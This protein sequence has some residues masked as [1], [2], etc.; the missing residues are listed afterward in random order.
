MRSSRTRF[1]SFYAPN[2]CVPNNSQ[3]WVGP[4]GSEGALFSLKIKQMNSGLSPFI[5][6]LYNKN[7]NHKKLRFIEQLLCA[8][9]CTKTFRNSHIKS[10]DYPHQT[11]REQG[12][13]GAVVSVECVFSMREALE[14]GKKGRRRKGKKMR[15]RDGKQCTVREEIVARLTPVP[16]LLPTKPCSLCFI[17]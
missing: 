9:H 14:A 8:R 2:K 12:L 6:I 3:S 7:H 11:V 15:L 10:N 13:T 5:R 4:W 1:N 17:F 16:V